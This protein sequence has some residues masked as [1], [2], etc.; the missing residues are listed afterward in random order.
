MSDEDTNY[1]IFSCLGVVGRAQSDGRFAPVV[2]GDR[3]M[4]QDLHMVLMVRLVVEVIKENYSGFF[5][6]LGEDKS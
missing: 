3:F 1:I 6:G 5:M 2:A 4:F